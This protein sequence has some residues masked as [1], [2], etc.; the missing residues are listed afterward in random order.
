MACCIYLVNSFIKKSNASKPTESNTIWLPVP[1]DGRRRGAHGSIINNSVVYLFYRV[2][3]DFLSN[4]KDILTSLNNQMSSQ[5]KNDMPKK[6]NQLLGLMRHIPTRLYYYL[7]NKNSEKA[8]TSFLYSSTGENIN[9]MK[10]FLAAPISD[11]VIYPPQTFPPGITFSFLRYNNALK[12]NI[13]YSKNTI[14]VDEESQLVT[15]IKSLL[16]NNT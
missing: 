9:S 2:E 11:V 3:T 8:F 14:S 7:I 15:S 12:V 1:Y 5:I 16:L 10:T 4:V 6:Y 13:M